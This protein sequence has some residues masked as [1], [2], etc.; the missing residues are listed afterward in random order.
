M[1]E[2]MQAD[3]VQRRQAGFVRCCLRIYDITLKGERC[4]NYVPIDKMANYNREND[5]VRQNE[6]YDRQPVRRK[7]GIFSS[8]F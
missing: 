5:A 4:G 1:T 2:N 7:K 6:Y 8:L 3:F